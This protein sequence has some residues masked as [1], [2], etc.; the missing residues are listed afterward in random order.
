MNRTAKNRRTRAAGI[1]ALGAVTLSCNVP[2]AAATP[3]P[4]N[5]N[6]RADKDKATLEEMLISGLKVR[7]KSEKQFI[8]RV[9]KLVDD[10]KLS[11]SLVKALFQRA[12]DQHSRYPL[13]Y[14][15]AILLKVAQQRGVQL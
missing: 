4:A 9:S 11:E 2:V 8:A 10:G 14:F 15:T 13:P 6:R 7:T 3:A 5:V 1:L 12:R